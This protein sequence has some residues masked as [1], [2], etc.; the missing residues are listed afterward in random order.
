MEKLDRCY[1][2]HHDITGRY[3][4]PLDRRPSEYLQ[5][6]V[7]IAPGFIDDIRAHRTARADLHGWDYPH[8][9]GLLSPYEEYAKLVGARYRRR[10]PAPAAATPPSLCSA[11]PS[12]DRSETL[13][14]VDSGDGRRPV[15]PP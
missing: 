9:E 6:R 7:R 15:R 10:C 11:D 12:A 13:A 1:D 3:L 5:D 14:G 4:V 2:H 8:C